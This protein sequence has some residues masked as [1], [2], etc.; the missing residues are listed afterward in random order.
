M[1]HFKTPADG[2]MTHLAADIGIAAVADQ[3][4]RGEQDRVTSSRVVKKL[5]P[6]EPNAAL[7]ASLG[8][9]TYV[10]PPRGAN[11]GQLD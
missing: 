8:V 5:H 10:S 4:S 6:V 1:E 9:H 2:S 11:I 3:V 7:R